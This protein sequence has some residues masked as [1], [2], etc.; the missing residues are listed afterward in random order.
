LTVAALALSFAA[1]TG[2][3]KPETSETKPQTPSSTTATEAPTE[4]ADK[5]EPEKTE[6]QKP[7]FKQVVLVDNDDVTVTIV[8]IDDDTMW[9]FG[10]NVFL[11]NKTD[12]ELMFALDNVSINGFM[13]DPLWAKSVAAGMKSNTEISWFENDLEK[14]NITN[15]EEVTFTLRI[16][17]ANNPLGKDVF[18][19]TFTTKFEG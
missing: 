12:K 5:T 2:T 6:P 18:K 19:D 15:V 14:N 11:E 16:Y 10:L 8:S 17:D 13:C 9:G 1:C 4:G 3:S 7:E